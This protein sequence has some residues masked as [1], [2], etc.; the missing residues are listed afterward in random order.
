MPT[1]RAQ[2]GGS[3]LAGLGCLVGALCLGSA[4]ALAGFLLGLASYFRAQAT[5]LEDV[6][7][8]AGY[9]D[10][11]EAAVAWCGL[12]ALGSLVATGALILI[13]KEL[14]DESARKQRGAV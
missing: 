5:V 7:D 8:T 12:G 13:L 3:V 11:L 6:N 2:E 9:L 1:P 4:L 14:A 10:T